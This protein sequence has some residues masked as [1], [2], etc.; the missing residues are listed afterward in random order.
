MHFIIRKPWDVP[1][2]R[3]TPVNVYRRRSVHR[4]EFLQVMGLSAIGGVLAAGSTGCS[5]ATDKEIEVAGAVE[6]APTI[7]GLYP[8]QRDNRFEYDRPETAKRD[9]AEYTNFYEFSPNKDSWM[10]VGKFQPQPWTVEVDGLCSKPRKFDLDD[11]HKMFSLQERAYRHR[12]VETWAMCVPWTGFPLR[13]LIKKVE[14]NPKAKFVRLETFNRPAQAA[15]MRYEP[16]YPWPYTESLSIAEATNDLALLATGI[17]GEPLPKQHGAPVRLVV[18]WKYGFKSI[19][20]ITKMTLTD[21]QPPT[22]WNTLAPEEYDTVANVDPDVP[23]PRWSQRTEWML[24]TYERYETTVYNGYAEFVGE[25][26][27]NKG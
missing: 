26:Y 12:C 24:G 9:A 19:K 15:H 17:Y 18:P 8:A 21:E 23:H 16:Q 25:L 2:H 27:H 7:A 22:F 14:P 5:R 6:A 4:R 10:Y 20:S 11:L 13:E 1:Q 3:H